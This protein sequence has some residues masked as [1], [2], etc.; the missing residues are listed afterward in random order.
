[1]RGGRGGG[2]GGG[3][4]VSTGEDT[5]LSSSDE[6]MGE[7]AGLDEEEDG[8]GDCD[9]AGWWVGTGTAVGAGDTA[10]T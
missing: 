6:E 3:E 1:M 8:D 7:L 5:A 4:V 10:G 2:I 9:T